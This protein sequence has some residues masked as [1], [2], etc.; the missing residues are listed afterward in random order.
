MPPKQ[1][2]EEILKKKREAAKARLIKIKNDPIKLEEYKEKERLKY[3]K[4]KKEKGQRKTISEMTPRQQRKTRKMWRK[5][6]AEHRRK[7]VISDKTNY[8]MR[9]STPPAS[10]D[11]MH[12]HIAPE[13]E[14]NRRRREAQNRSQR[15]RRLRIK[16][17][18]E[19][20][21]L[22]CALK[23]KLNS[24]R[25]KYRRFKNKMKKDRS[26]VTPKSKIQQMAE[27]PQQKNELVKKAL[28]GEVMQ[29]QI[30]LNISSATTHQDRSNFKRFLA[31]KI[32]D[33][34]KLWR[35][36]NVGFTYKNLGHNKTKPVGSNDKQKLR[37]V[38]QTFY[39]DDSNSRQAAGK[40]ECISHQN[41][42]K[43]KRYLMDSLQ[44][45]HKKFLQMGQQK[46]SYALFC[47]LR[48]YWVIP[49]KVSDRETCAC[50]THENVDLKI[51]ALQNSKILGFNSF[52]K[53]LQIL[54]CD[55]YSE[56][57]LARTCDTCA[58]N[59]LHYDEYDDKRDITFKQWV[60]A[61]E[62]IQDQTTKKERYVTKYKKQVKEVKPKDLILQLEG[63]VQKLLKHERNI[64]HQYETIKSLKQILTDKDAIIHMDFSE[65]Y[66]AKYNREIQ[67]F[68]FGGSRM[69]ICLH[70]VVVYTKD[71]T[72]CYCTISSNLSHNVGAIW[73]HL[74]PV[75]KSL[76]STVE[77]LHFLSDGPV[78]QYRNKTMFFILACRLLE[79]YSNTITF[80]WNY[81][82][83][84][85]G[86]GAPDGIG[87]TCKRTADQ[88]IAQN[89]D[90]T[91]LDE[92]V[93]ALR[94]KCPRI[95]IY[96]IEQAAI[97]KVSNMIRESERKLVSFKGTLLVHQVSGSI[98]R[99]NRLL[100][101]EL[102]CFCDPDACEH[103]KLGILEYENNVDHL[104]VDNIFTDSE[105]EFLKQAP[106]TNKA[107]LSFGSGDYILVKF[108]MGK[109]EYRYAA[110]CSNF[111]EEE[112]EL[113]VTFLKV[114]D[115][116][117]TLF[118]VDEND[119][120]DISLDHVIE[121]LSIPNL[122]FKGNRL[123][124][125]FKKSVNVFEK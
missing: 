84:G 117:L 10:D 95:N 16:E 74:E 27:D 47:R 4:K 102:S 99:P 121:K 87:A 5:Y 57:C 125:K 94:E 114:C 66:N 120:A 29:T 36:N 32:V 18:K 89:R 123:F 91:N 62:L 56:N 1:K 63:D 64:V 77:N 19:K 98:Y 12:A 51:S 40:K 11:E 39:E 78:T 106:D 107:K 71:S 119:V 122:N 124:Y 46:I 109:K 2:R 70:T 85:H 33:K 67:S 31:G 15:Q 100:M 79:F 28:F 25:Q 105:T 82:E 55:R 42:T 17:I 96:V 113:T 38:V 45:L 44:N 52:Q 43:Q 58:A 90:I 59:T 37:N 3:L 13:N 97:E 75:L 110:I 108:P 83:A 48:P 103:Y 35:H 30:S 111:D 61:R 92:F 116:N 65:N 86:K 93:H 34:Y 112:E 23:S 7:Q 26:F 88:M 20:D 6:S 50:I 14:E 41:V 101:K 72:A 54:C 60:H 22:I 115:D 49:P 21:K 81:H 73:A 24:Q 104:D 9:C 80:S 118:R 8:F 68:H 53:L 76:P 69:Q